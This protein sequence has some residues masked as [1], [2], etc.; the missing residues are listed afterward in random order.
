MNRPDALSEASPAILFVDAHVHIHGC[1][2]CERFFDAAAANFAQAKADLPAGGDVYGAIMLTEGA[3]DDRFEALANGG[4]ATGAWQI[5]AT[6]E[7]VSLVASRPGVPPIFVIA[8]RQIATAE[9]LEVLALG[10]RARPPDGSP[11]SETLAVLA[12]S[13]ALAVIPWGF[14]KWSG[15]RGRYLT[16]LFAEPAGSP[17]YAGDN[18]GRP[19]AFLRPKLLAF[20]EGHGKLVLPGTDP[21]PFPGEIGKVGRYGFVAELEFDRTRPFASLRRWL[22]RQQTSPRTYGRLEGLWTFLDRQMRLHSKR[23]GGKRWKHAAGMS[24]T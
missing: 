16:R 10:T 11:L 4:A 22:E 5:A 17:L 24:R 13:D 14:G 9:R 2:A 7:A 20:A 21:L 6:S 12:A 15:R 3:D 23:F 18:G 1:F 8:G 19:G